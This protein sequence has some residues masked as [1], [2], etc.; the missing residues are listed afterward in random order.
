MLDP[1]EPGKGTRVRVQFGTFLAR[2]GKWTQMAS[3][4]S[5]TRILQDD[6]SP[7]KSCHS[8][9]GEGS[10]GWDKW[11][12]FVTVISRCL[13]CV[14]VGGGMCPVREGIAITLVF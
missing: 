4:S 5:D 10:V 11:E 7:W 13:L 8:S 1:S 3:L 14:C 2:L 12:L 9:L 6:Q